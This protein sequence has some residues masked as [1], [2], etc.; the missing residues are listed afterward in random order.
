MTTDFTK[1][2]P[3]VFTNVNTATPDLVTTSFGTTYN[4]TSGGDLSGLPGGFTIQSNSTNL[5]AGENYMFIENGQESDDTKPMYY[6]Q[7]ASDPYKSTFFLEPVGQ[8]PLD[9][10]PICFAAGYLIKYM[11][12]S[13][14]RG[15]VWYLGWE[16]GWTDALDAGFQFGDT[17]VSPTDPEAYTWIF[18]LVPTSALAPCSG[19]AGTCGAAVSFDILNVSGAWQGSVASSGG[20]ALTYSGAPVSYANDCS[21]C[22]QF[23]SPSPGGSTPSSPP[24]PGGSP[25]VTPSSAS[26]SPGGSPIIPPS[27]SGA[28]ANSPSWT[29]NFLHSQYLWI[30]L[31]IFAFVVLVLVFLYYRNRKSDAPATTPSS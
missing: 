10:T 26:P 2:D 28:P 21:S 4:W 8:A 20:C 22:P 19:T 12:D 31:G 30:G 5:S 11:W 16:P 23:A 3:L 7:E 9:G 1:A 15:N 27:S 13:T 25:I 6:S 24:S 29:S 18:Y 17:P 14:D